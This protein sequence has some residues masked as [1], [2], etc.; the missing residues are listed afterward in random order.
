MLKTGLTNTLNSKIIN[1]ALSEK[2]GKENFYQGF[3]FASKLSG[4]GNDIVNVIALDSL[5]I[6]ATF[7]KMHLEGG[8]YNAIIGARQ[9]IKKNRPILAITLYHNKDGVWRTSLFLMNLLENYRFYF[10][11]HS[12]AG[13]GAVLYAISEERLG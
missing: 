5:N 12:W 1:L 6:D 10:R 11:L 9:T 8:E 3:G 7:I 4:Y 13:T 2:E